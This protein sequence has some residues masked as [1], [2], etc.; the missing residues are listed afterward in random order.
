MTYLP[1]RVSSGS[2][3][4][5]GLKIV[6]QNKT[7]FFSWESFLRIFIGIVDEPVFESPPTPYIRIKAA[8]E[9]LFANEKEPQV[10]KRI[11]RKIY[12][13]FFIRDL[14]QPLRMEASAVDYRSFLSGVGP[15]SLHNLKKFLEA[16]AEKLPPA[17]LDSS[18][19][20]YLNNEKEPALIFPNVYEFQ[21]NCRERFKKVMES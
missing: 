14:N 6:L 11:R 10:Q 8:F 17:A 16:L 4:P 18:Y 1:H 12:I 3:E 13:D 5:G 7:D 21:E 15:N 9:K 2:I 20:A 19:S